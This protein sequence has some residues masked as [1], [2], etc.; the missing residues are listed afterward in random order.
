MALEPTEEERRI[1]GG[2][3][4]PAHDCHLNRTAAERWAAIRDMVLEAAALR[5][6]EVPENNVFERLC[7]E[8]I[9]A[10]KGTP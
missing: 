4:N 3:G 8:R 7:A 6:E 9:R 2:C 10:L 5:C 1:L